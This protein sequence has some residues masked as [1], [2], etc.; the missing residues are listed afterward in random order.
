MEIKD[1]L[2]IAQ[3]FTDTPGAR[4]Y[5]DGDYSG[6]EFLDKYLHERFMK[7]VNENYIIDINLDGLW[8]W[9]SSFISGSF[10]MLSMKVGAELILKHIHFTSTKRPSR[11]E[12]VIA[13]IKNP[14]KK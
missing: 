7:A 9:P 5:E 11:I 10:G 4:D 1:T 2:I 8:G 3:E 6:Q 14:T 13:E 12:K